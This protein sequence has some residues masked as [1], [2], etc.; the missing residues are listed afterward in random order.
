VAGVVGSVVGGAAATEGA[1]LA[2]AVDDTTGP[3]ETTFPPLG[4][5]LDAGWAGPAAAFVA[6]AAPVPTRRA[7]ERS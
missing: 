5:L 1:V 6:A 7:A 2:G 4:E 3:A